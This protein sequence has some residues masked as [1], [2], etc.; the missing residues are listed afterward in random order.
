MPNICP[1]CRKA[2]VVQQGL[3]LNCYRSLNSWLLS[4]CKELKYSDIR[5]GLILIVGTQIAD[6]L[7]EVTG[8]QSS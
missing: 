3:C 4:K 1:A 6:W 8:D 2:E 5:T 7:K